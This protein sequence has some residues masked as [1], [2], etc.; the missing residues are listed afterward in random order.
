MTRLRLTVN[1]TKT[2][3]CRIPNETFDFLGYTFGRCYDRR[4][5]RAYIG[6][7]PSKKRIRRI[8]KEIRESTGRKWT[9]MAADE[10]VAHLNRKIKGWANYYCLGPVSR[11]YRAVDS[12]V[13]NR[14]RQWLCAKHQVQG[15]GTARWPDE[16][17]YG[18]LGLVRLER[19]TR[20]LPWAKA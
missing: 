4:T 6:T 8:C 2:R 14:L 19:L 18:T 1:E 5:G 17:L 9:F 16:T 12:H 20:N 15:R 11:A 10:M 13:R 3:L 7:R